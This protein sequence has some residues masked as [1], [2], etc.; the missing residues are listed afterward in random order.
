MYINQNLNN[1]INNKLQ[2]V[3]FI[4]YFIGTLG[5]YRLL[6]SKN[7]ATRILCFFLSILNFFPTGFYLRLT[8]KPEIMAFAFYLG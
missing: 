2:L 7:I 8:M 4:Y 3:N 6:K 5:L 1:L